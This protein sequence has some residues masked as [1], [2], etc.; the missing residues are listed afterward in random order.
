[1]SHAHI[2]LASITQ[3]AHFFD[4]KAYDFPWAVHTTLEAACALITIPDVT[5]APNLRRRDHFPD[6][7]DHITQSLIKYGVIRPLLLCPEEG[8]KTALKSTKQWA[9]LHTESLKKCLK[10]FRSDENYLRWIDWQTN[11]VWPGHVIRY[12]GLF[13]RDLSSYVA[14]V[15]DLDE[16]YLINLNDHITHAKN[17]KSEIKNIS[18]KD[19]L[20]HLQE[21][22]L[23]S[24]WLRGR[25]HE[26]VAVKRKFQLFQ[27]PIRDS[28]L[29]IMEGK[30]YE[31]GLSDTTW[32]LANIIVSGATKQSSTK[33]RIECW[34]NNIKQVQ[35][36]SRLGMLDLRPKDNDTAMRE[37]AFSAAK[38]SRITVNNKTIDKCLE[39]LATCGIGTLIGFTLHPIAGIGGSVASEII[40]GKTRYVKK[41][42]N[43]F[44]LRKKHLS[45]LAEHGPGK[46][47][48]RWQK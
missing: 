38:R 35:E 6:Y 13:D 28:V 42:I 21:S 16:T 12:K 39:H 31:F 14:N 11:K 43:T 4:E 5:I 47:S 45:R 1:M 40:E 10:I 8:N 46:I 44:H 15:V 30:S 34:V 19:E 18:S 17:P 27:H 25:F 7:V 36:L 3:I 24:S 2:D 20:K 29:P 26:R 33:K 23:V 48:K 22:F 41:A 37:A 9:S 32:Y